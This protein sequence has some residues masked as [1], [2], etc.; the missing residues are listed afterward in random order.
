[1]QDGDADPHT[2]R[3]FSYSVVEHRVT[4]DPQRA[5]LLTGPLQ[6]ETDDVTDQR[7]A[8]RRAVT[9]RRRGDVDRWSPRCLE[10]RRTPRFEPTCVTAEALRSRGGGDDDARRRQQGAPGVVEVVGVVIVGEQHRVDRSEVGGLDR[11]PR[12]LPRTRAPTEVVRATRAVEASDRSRSATRRNSM[13]TV[14]PPMCVSQTVL[15]LARS[16]R[17]APGRSGPARY[18]RDTRLPTLAHALTRASTSA[19][20]RA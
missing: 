8:Q 18:C 17:C 4:R 3:D 20:S 5:M 13:S 6:R 15:M 12:D 9:T 14:G 11:R 19:Q 7:M 16:R 1:M 2:V 10:S